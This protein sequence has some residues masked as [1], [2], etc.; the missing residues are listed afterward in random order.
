MLKTAEGQRVAIRP[1][2]VEDRKTSDVSLMPEGLAE[3]M[4]DQDL[5]DLLAYPLDAPSSR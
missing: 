3:T 1:G 4:T 2:E 5:V